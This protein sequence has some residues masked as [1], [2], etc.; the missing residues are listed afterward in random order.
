MLP[1][2]LG[3]SESVSRRRTHFH[4]TNRGGPRTLHHIGQHQCQCRPGTPLRG[5]ATGHLSAE[6]GELQL[7]LLGY[8]GERAWKL[9]TRASK[10]GLL[11]ATRAAANATVTRAE[12]DDLTGRLMG[13]PA[14]F[15][16]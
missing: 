16:R 10:C 15:G 13:A 7:K 1:D 9:Y 5:G 14:S 3:R 8:W 12:A 4:T 2:N 6:T 11:K